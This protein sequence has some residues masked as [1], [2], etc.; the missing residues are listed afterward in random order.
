MI[1]LIS[2][3]TM[4]VGVH[5]DGWPSVLSEIKSFESP[6]GILFDD[7]VE[8]TYFHP[9]PEL[10]DFVPNEPWAG[11]FHYPPDVP[12]WFRR[13]ARINGLETSS[14]W[15]EAAPYVRLGIAFAPNIS[16]WVQDKL[17]IPCLLLKHP[18]N[19]PD[20]TWTEER[21]E[22][23]PTKALIQAGSFLR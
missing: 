18:S 17:N 19:T 9:P 22:A 1:R 20:L 15:L 16:R 6:D 13:E 11:I 23:N 3:P 8:R 5:R 7:Y 12:D 4:G 14:R 2:A 21:F 10:E